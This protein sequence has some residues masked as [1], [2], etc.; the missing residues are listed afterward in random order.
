MTIP[1]GI[2]LTIQKSL[3]ATK[4]VLGVSGDGGRLVGEKC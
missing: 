3:L 2:D 4:S 1:V